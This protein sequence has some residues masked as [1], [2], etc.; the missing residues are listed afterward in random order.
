M[1][2]DKRIRRA[3]ILCC[4]CLR[5]IA[6]YRAG[7]RGKTLRVP[8]QFW[9]NANSNF[10][11]I[12]V[13]EWCKLFTER[14]GKHHWK[15]VVSDRDKFRAGLERETG[16]SWR[17]FRQYAL[18]VL[19]YRDTFV[20]HLDDEETMYPPRLRVMRKSAGY[21]YKYIIANEA[22]PGLLA[23]ASP[24]TEFYSKFFRHARKQYARAT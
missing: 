13:L 16:M 1:T 22:K 24:L 14:D 18:E 23:D 21:L 10:I 3:A 2:R 6:F 9:I 11:D 8:V 15:A 12:A 4:H 17:Q 20:A 5:N 19:E 7:W